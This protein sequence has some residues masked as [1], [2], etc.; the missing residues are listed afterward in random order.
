MCVECPQGAFCGGLPSENV[1]A[2][3]GSWRV[4][5]ARHGLLFQACPEPEVCQGTPT[6]IDLI[7]EELTAEAP[8]ASE[9]SGDGVNQDEGEAALGEALRRRRASDQMV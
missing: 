1:T 7:V 8:A 2:R 9:E 4:P 5:W 6:D 3:S